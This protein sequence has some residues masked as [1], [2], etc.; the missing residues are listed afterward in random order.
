[1]LWQ[2]AKKNVHYYQ[3][4]DD[5]DIWLHKIV[6]EM[7]IWVNM[8]F[9]NGVGVFIGGDDMERGCCFWGDGCYHVNFK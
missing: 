8:F 2:E 9:D 4:L 7:G 1:L 6:V 5:D 3:K